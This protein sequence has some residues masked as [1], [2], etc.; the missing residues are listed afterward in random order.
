MRG[1]DADA[2]RQL[3]T[4]VHDRAQMLE[5]VA[6]ALPLSG[7][8]LQKDAQLS[9]SQSFASDL[10]TER[11]GGDAVSFARAAGTTRMNNYIV[12]AQRNAALHFFTERSDRFQQNHIVRRRKV[13]QI[14]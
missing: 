1:V 11:S 5:P 6:D 10:Q 8:V 2:E 14:V 13:N 3:R 7:S 9:E 4:R 12:G